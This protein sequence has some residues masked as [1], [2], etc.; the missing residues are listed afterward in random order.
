MRSSPGIGLRQDRAV[1]AVR[2]ERKVGGAG[3]AKKRLSGC[4]CRGGC[5]ANCGALYAKT[6]HQPFGG[7]LKVVAEERAEQGKVLCGEAPLAAIRGCGLGRVVLRGSGMGCIVLCGC[8]LGCV[9]LRGCGQE[10][11]DVVDGAAVVGCQLCVDR[12]GLVGD[13]AL[14]EIERDPTVDGTDKLEVRAG[15]GGDGGGVTQL[16]RYAEGDVGAELCAK[17]QQELEELQAKYNEHPLAKAVKQSRNNFAAMMRDVNSTL[18]Q[19]LNP[20][21]TQARGCSGACSTC[22]GC[23]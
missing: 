13:G 21:G 6:L 14:R 7:S 12:A 15:A 9:V 22:A 18:Q 16:R 23:E 1:G 4:I 5:G 3:T 8:G 10:S 19:S 17:G 2:A 20:E 11:T